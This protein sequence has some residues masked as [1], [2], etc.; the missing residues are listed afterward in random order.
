M[1]FYQF[2]IRR[3]G[4][5]VEASPHWGGVSLCTFRGEAERS[6]LCPGCLERQEEYPPQ[7]IMAPVVL[8]YVTRLFFWKSM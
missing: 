1:N 2:W 8:R 5:G 4:E 7:E 6:I 3:F